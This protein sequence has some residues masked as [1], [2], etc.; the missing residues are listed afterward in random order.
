[1]KK[2]IFLVLICLTLAACNN[3]EKN[4][5][6]QETDNTDTAEETDAAASEEEE[7]IPTYQIGE[8][9]TI[10]S[11]LYAFDYE[12]TVNDFQLT[13]EVDEVPIE[14]YLI[15]AREEDRFAVVDVTIKNISEEAYVPNQM[16]S[17]NFSAIDEDG[18]DISND[19]FFTAGDE[20]LAPG[21]ELTGHLV[22]L[23]DINY[24]DTFVLKYEF[25]SDQE[26]H[27]ELPNPEQ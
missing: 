17:A 22:Y 27:F 9:A 10:S 18:G 16:F 26:T 12:V 8:T 25:M 2:F 1:M 23:T 7:E 6:T 24:A 14:D 21:E 20:E 11:D 19:E 3:G 5:E 15:G 4:T 13:R